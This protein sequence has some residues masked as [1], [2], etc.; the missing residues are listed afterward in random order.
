[1]V[2]LKILQLFGY[3]VLTI[4]AF[5]ILTVLIAFLVELWRAFFKRDKK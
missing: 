2:F 4:V 1:M 5:I 3:G